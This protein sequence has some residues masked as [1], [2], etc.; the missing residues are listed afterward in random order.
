MGP[1]WMKAHTTT[2]S[3]PLVELVAWS[4][5]GWIRFEWCDSLGGEWMPVAKSHHQHH[6][7]NTYQIYMHPMSE[8]TQ[9][10]LESEAGFFRIGTHWNNKIYSVDMSEVFPAPVP[11]VGP[12]NPYLKAASIPPTPGG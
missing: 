7:K 9:R 3:A 6:G 11:F 5:H 4:E 2:A 8:V 12:P 1:N 10:M